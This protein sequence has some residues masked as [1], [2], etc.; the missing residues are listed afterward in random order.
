MLYPA[1]YADQSNLTILKCNLCNLQVILPRTR[2]TPSKQADQYTLSIL[3]Y[4]YFKLLNKTMT[5][6][7]LT[8]TI[9]LYL[10]CTQYIY[11]EDCQSKT[12]NLSFFSVGK[13]GGYNIWRQY[14]CSPSRVCPRLVFQDVNAGMT[15]LS[16]MYRNNI[17]L[18]EGKECFYNKVNFLLFY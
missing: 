12:S 13:G 1:N 11:S 15:K 4:E 8:Y 3:K 6:K 7:K 5:S 14:L 16:C 17:H 2:D 9:C 10:I 18:F